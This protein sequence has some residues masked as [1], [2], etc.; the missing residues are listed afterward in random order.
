MLT[1]NTGAKEAD[2]ESDVWCDWDKRCH[3]PIDDQGD[4]YPEGFI[5]SCC[6][7]SRDSEGCRVGRH[8]E[9]VGGGR[10]YK[11]VRC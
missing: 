8:K 3:G 4:A 6:D 1:R 2:Y 5:W 9:F 11:R 7:D 10:P